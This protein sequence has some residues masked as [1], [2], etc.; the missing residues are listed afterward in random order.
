TADAAD[1]LDRLTRQRADLVVLDL[2]LP[3]TDGLE[4]CR[5]IRARLGRSIAILMVSARGRSGVIDCLA[6]GAD[7]YLGKPFDVNELEAR[8]R[9]LLRA[10]SLEIAAVRRSERLLSLQR[11]ST[12]IV[13]RLD[14]DEIL[15][16]VL[17]ESRRLLKA[18][19]VALYVWDPGSKLLQP[20]RMS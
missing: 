7:D 13:A 12:A 19:G 10:R 3:G 20:R 2:M 9:T 1:A 6:A 8:V 17:A 4:A 11:I 5:Q 18:S 15:D 16:L 14:E